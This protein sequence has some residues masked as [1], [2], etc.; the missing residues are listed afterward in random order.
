MK[1]YTRF[2]LRQIQIIQLV[3]LAASLLMLPFV[4]WSMGN[5]LLAVLFFHLYFSVG[6][7]MMYH[8][9]WSHKAFEFK[10]QWMKWALTVFACFAGR[11]SALS[12]VHIHRTHHAHS[13]TGDDP[14]RPSK[15]LKLFSFNSTGIRE[16][17][18]FK[19]RDLLDPYNVAMHDY[20]LLILL[21]WVGFVSLFGLSALYFVWILPVCLNQIVGDLWNHYSHVDGGYR[22]YNTRDNSKN[23]PWLWPFIFGEAWHNN[24]HHDP[25]N[26][27][28][29]KKWW[30]LDPVSWLIKL[31]S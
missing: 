20:Y 23:V 27:S 30:E 31:L 19:I 24:H 9:F 1:E 4:E 21:G 3:A 14:H 11:G 29:K 2:S 22:S 7:S 28:T 5:I 10:W 18:R 6:I 26:V 16:V 15:R 25:K 12:W 8:R 13:D 17:N